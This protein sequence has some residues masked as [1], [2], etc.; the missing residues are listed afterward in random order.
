MAHVRHFKKG[1]IRNIIKEHERDTDHYK[2][3]VDVSRS[4]LN[5]GYGYQNADAVALQIK[6]RC[7]DIMHGKKMQEQTNVM[8]E[9]KITYPSW[10]CDEVKGQN[11]RMYNKPRDPAHVKEFFDTVYKFTVE[12][13]GESNV[14]G[15]YVHMD[16][17]TPHM[18][19]DLVPEAT[20]RKTGK[21]T[22]SSASLFDKKELVSYQKD[23]Q[24]T[25]IKTFGK[26]ANA[27][28]LNGRTKGNY[29]MEELKERTRNNKS[30]KNKQKELD[31]REKALDERE[32]ELNRFY[33][34]KHSNLQENYDKAYQ[35]MQYEFDEMKKQW[36][37]DANNNYDE[38]LKEQENKANDM[39]NEL[40]ETIDYY[41]EQA[42]MFD[43][44]VIAISS[45]P[46]REKVN[47]RLERMREAEL[48]MSSN[49][50]SRDFSL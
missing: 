45:L 40:Q 39:F 35:H 46:V 15:G 7:M 48:L 25:M 47:K 1:D 44:P 31:L 12:R 28:I 19:I 36:L 3:D 10:L 26:E 9:W 5:F 16:E 24:D 43:Q 50:Q 30:I 6:A 21:Q 20:S 49:G 29:T 8:S 32:D 2:N 41:N 4:Y 18:H 34:K 23:L 37:K 38:W 42:T 27:Y 17:T 33:E 22:V 11:G 14:I 13:Y